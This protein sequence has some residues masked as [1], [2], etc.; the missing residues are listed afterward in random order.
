MLVLHAAS[1]SDSTDPRVGF[2][3]PRAV[4]TAVVRNTVRRR[5]R[6][7]MQARLEQLPPGTDLVVRIL[8]AAAGADSS[9]LAEALDRGL[10]KVVAR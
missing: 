5:L 1:A 10:R 3:V 7:L 2:V 6:H 9:T 4:G 8:P